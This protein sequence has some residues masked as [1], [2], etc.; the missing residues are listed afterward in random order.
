MLIDAHCHLERDYYGDTLPDV[1]ER[2]REAGVTHMIAVGASRVTQGAEEA[3]A[4]AA[5]HP[6]IYAT[7]GIHPHEASKAD[8][9]AMAQIEAHLDD[10]KVVAV[11]EVGLDYYYDNSPRDAQQRVFRR[12]LEM[13]KAHDLPV[14]L[15]VRDPLAHEHTW[16]LLDDVG[17]SERGGVVHCFSAGPKEAAEYVARGMS[18]SIPGIVTFKNADDLREAVRQTPL[19]RLLV[20]TDAPY[21]APIPHRGK[22]NEPA[23]VVHTVHKVAEL[24]GISFEEAAA[25]TAGNAVR[26]FGLGGP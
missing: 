26:L 13:A 23:F 18:L 11:G 21:L 20:E 6:H 19:E 15:H 2:A 1:I 8:D 14:M 22:P 25:A 7:A 9:A 3:R 10:P 17:L 16:Q 5:A 4:L 24:K 12:F